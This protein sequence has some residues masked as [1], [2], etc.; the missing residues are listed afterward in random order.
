MDPDQQQDTRSI[1]EVN[2]QTD[3]TYRETQALY[4]QAARDYRAAAESSRRA[5]TMFNVAIGVLFAG[6]IAYGIWDYSRK[7]R[8]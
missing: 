5:K 1:E 8:R 3:A 4:E 6:T 7:S 2:Q